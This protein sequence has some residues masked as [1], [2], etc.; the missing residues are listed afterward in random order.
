[1]I[2]LRSLTISLKFHCIALSFKWSD[3]LIIHLYRHFVG[4]ALTFIMNNM[5]FLCTIERLIS[6]KLRF[7]LFTPG[8]SGSCSPIEE[9]INFSSCLRRW[10]LPGKHSNFYW[11]LVCG[12]NS[13]LDVS[14]FST[15]HLPNWC[16]SSM[17]TV[18]LR[19]IIWCSSNITISFWS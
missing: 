3:A 12:Q 11:R 2:D 10:V 9:I 17:C 8:I 13:T 15:S 16:W 7:T 14:S 5:I 18:C 4:V 6:Q 1:M 19:L